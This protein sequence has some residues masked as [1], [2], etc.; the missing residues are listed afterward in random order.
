MGENAL[1]PRSRTA[2]A[3]L[4]TALVAAGCGSDDDPKSGVSDEPDAKT[5]QSAEEPA[6]PKKASARSKLVSCVEGEGYEISHEGDDAEK[7]TDYTIGPDDPKRAKAQVKIH[8]N[9]GDA[10][11][12]ARRAGEDEGINAVVF[13]RAE[14]IR[15][16]ATDTEAGRIVNCLSAAYGG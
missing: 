10:A 11:S 15:L 16:Q 7:A 14:F 5:E 8:S 6:A 2:L 12:S 9:R 13:G 3:I 4:L 1:M